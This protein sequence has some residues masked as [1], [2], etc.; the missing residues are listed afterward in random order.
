MTTLFL[1]IAGIIAAI[2]TL[3]LV[4]IPVDVVAGAFTALRQGDRDGKGPNRLS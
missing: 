3:W 4:V 1:T 2:L